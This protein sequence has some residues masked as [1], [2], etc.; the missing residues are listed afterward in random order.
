L[1]VVS[2]LSKPAPIACQFEISDYLGSQISQREF[3]SSET[4]SDVS[5]GYEDVG[6]IPEE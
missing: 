6:A 3:A 5:K 1:I 4:R 2:L